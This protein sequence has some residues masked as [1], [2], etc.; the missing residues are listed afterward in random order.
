MNKTC[1][2]AEWQEILSPSEWEAVDEMITDP[3]NTPLTS[4]EVLDAI[5]RWNGGIADSYYLRA[6][7]YKLY[8]VKL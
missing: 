6:L 2:K 4:N 5:V 8:M 7:I 3:M 1:T